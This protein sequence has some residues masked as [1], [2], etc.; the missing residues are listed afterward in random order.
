MHKILAF[1]A[2]IIISVSAYSATPTAESI[3]A[4]LVATKAE[5]MLDSV[6]ENLERVMKQTLSQRIRGESI[7][8]EQQRFL[9]SLPAKYVQVMKE[10]MAWS[11]MRALYVQVYQES[12]TQEEVDGLLAFYKS[13]AGIAFVEKMPLVMEK[14]VAIMQSRMA[15]MIERMKATIQK[16]IE[17]AKTIR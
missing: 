15:P 14:S 13:P 3:D 16:A 1:L 8:I 10:E 4:L 2:S 5:R 6:L 9:D 11:N 7:T 12:F 17:D